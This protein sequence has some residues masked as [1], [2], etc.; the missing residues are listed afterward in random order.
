MS[1]QASTVRSHLFP[2][3]YGA[4]ATE[5]YEE[6]MKMADLDENESDGEEDMQ[7]GAGPE[8]ATTDLL[9]YIDAASR[10]GL[11]NLIPQLD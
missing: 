9:R 2:R 5:E 7:V 11:R 4:V 1:L 8:Q 3:Y 10:R 6:E